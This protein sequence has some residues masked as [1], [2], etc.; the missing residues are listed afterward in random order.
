LTIALITQKVRAAV[1][2]IIIR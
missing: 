1:L 2:K